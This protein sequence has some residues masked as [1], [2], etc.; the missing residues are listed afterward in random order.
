MRAM[1]FGTL[2]IALIGTASAQAEDNQPTLN[3]DQLINA[4]FSSLPAAD[5]S[6]VYEILDAKCEINELYCDEPMDYIGA[7]E[8]EIASL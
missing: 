8:V 1:I 3:V 4:T 2:L 7:D 5:D 6:V